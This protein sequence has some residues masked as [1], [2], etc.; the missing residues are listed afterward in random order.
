MS[1]LLSQPGWV[2]RKKW[3]RT[4]CITED[5][6]NMVTGGAQTVATWDVFACFTRPGK[7]RGWC[8]RL[9][10]VTVIR[11]VAQSPEDWDHFVIGASAVGIIPEQALEVL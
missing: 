4:S 11:P 3:I 6:K 8:A 1:S 10:I 7:A 2:A 9:R 5:G